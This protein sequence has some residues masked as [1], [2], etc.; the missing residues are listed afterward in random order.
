M[1]SVKQELEV[2][3]KQ[4]DS[5]VFPCIKNGGIVVPSTQC[6]TSNFTLGEKS[7]HEQQRQ[8]RSTAGSWKGNS[9]GQGASSGTWQ[10]S[11]TAQIISSDIQQKYLSEMQA[12]TAAYPRTQIWT[13]ENGIWLL[14][15]SALLNG[16]NLSATFL[17]CLP[18]DLTKTPKAWAFWNGLGWIGERHTNF[19]DGSI[20]AFEPSDGTWTPGESLVK[21][22]DLY[23]LWACKHYYLKEFGKW[24]GYQVG[25]FAYERFLE[26]KD[27]EFCGCNNFNKKY[28]DCCK[29]KDSGSTLLKSAIH[30]SVSI[31]YNKRKPPE[32]ILDFMYLG[33]S[34]PKILNL[35]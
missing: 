25:H 34:L 27:D 26:F 1:I 16:S 3:G 5:N 18:N 8:R 6:D 15:N 17:V 10:A 22:L 29:L 9:R 20:C 24:P 28:K 12:V 4:L 13:E 14:T 30:L 19:P 2:I 35:Y 11:N 7:E 21:L 33:E 31:G 32:S 23:T